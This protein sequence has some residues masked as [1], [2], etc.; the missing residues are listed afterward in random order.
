MYTEEQKNW[1]QEFLSRCESKVGAV[2][3]DIQKDY[4]YTTVDGKYDN[5]KAYVPFGWTSGFYGGIMW[6]L[7]QQTGDEKYKQRAIRCSQRMNGAFS[8]P[9]NFH[10]IDNH[11]VG[12][13]IGLTNVNHY[14]LLGDDDA[15]TRAHH[16]ALVLAGRYNLSGSFL[17]AWQGDSHRGYAIIDCL[18]NLPL[19]YWA[20][21]HCGDSRFSQIAKAHALTTAR[22][23]IKPDGS[24][25]HIVNFDP[26]TG[27]VVD[28]PVGQGIASGSSWS[29]GQSWSIYGFA[30]SYG[31]TGDPVF[32]KAARGTADYVMTHMEP[33]TLAPADF[34]Q[35]AE[36][37]LRDASATAIIASGML[38]L[39]KYC[40]NGQDYENFALGLL[41]ALYRDCD[42]G[43]EEQS[44]LQSCTMR[45]HDT[46]EQHI[47]IIYG[48]YFLIEALMKAAGKEPGMW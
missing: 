20:G 45:Y 26:D 8:D 43:T 36:P 37:D 39:A 34:M 44:L 29:R 1:V 30:L 42:F 46:P 31:Y 40:E 13:V 12:F 15:K 2:M 9:K 21:E 17:R 47:P 14:R 11:D 4:P 41:K 19:L 3:G 25:Y 7:Y 28:Y 48:D 10:C 35:P 18:M 22:E 23:F 16:A 6:L 24:V 27:S 5:E 38:E 32:L 33:G